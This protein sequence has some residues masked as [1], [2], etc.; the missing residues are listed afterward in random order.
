MLAM[1]LV[2]QWFTRGVHQWQ[3]TSW[4]CMHKTLGRS[5]RLEDGSFHQTWQVALTNKERAIN[6]RGYCLK[7]GEFGKQNTSIPIRKWLGWSAMAMTTLIYACLSLPQ[8][9]MRD[10]GC[11]AT[12]SLCQPTRVSSALP[13]TWRAPDKAEVSTLPSDAIRCYSESRGS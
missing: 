1:S 10:T 7:N 2:K 11:L 6:R 8:L 4:P 5:D 12:I 9:I 13:E 3:N